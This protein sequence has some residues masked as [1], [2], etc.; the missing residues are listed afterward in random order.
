V[1]AGWGGAYPIT[2]GDGNTKGSISKNRSRVL[3]FKLG[4]ASKLPEETAAAQLTPLARLGDNEAV[5]KGFGLF[6]TY[7][8]VCHGDAA[9]GG[10]VITDLR[11]SSVVADSTSWQAVVLDGDFKDRG[12][13][14]FAEVLNEADAEAV[15]AYITMRSNQSFVELQPEIAPAAAQAPDSQK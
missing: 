10:G 9:V 13:I 12:M 3:A 15:R 6:H 5:I 1:V 11:W 2:A 14:S 4:G 8:A 7:C